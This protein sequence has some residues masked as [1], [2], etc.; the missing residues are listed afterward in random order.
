MRTSTM[1][2][3]R[4]L[5]RANAVWISLPG[6]GGDL[7]LRPGAYA[8]RFLRRRQS[9]DVENAFGISPQAIG[10]FQAGF[11]RDITTRRLVRQSK[12]AL[13]SDSPAG[14]RTAKENESVSSVGL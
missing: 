3:T 13:P 8:S 1:R 11:P 6:R 12:D 5:V 10:L 7:P 9:V 14:R 2:E 4:Q